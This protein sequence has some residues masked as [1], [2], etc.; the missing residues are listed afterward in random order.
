MDTKA[1]AIVQNKQ[2]KKVICGDCILSLIKLHEV[3]PL[4]NFQL[5]KRNIMN[6]HDA[7]ELARTLMNEHGLI[8]WIFQYD[9]AK[10]RED[11]A[12]TADKPSPLAITMSLTTK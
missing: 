10:Q 12:N 3:Y 8:T 9:R 11:A 2:N 7:A 4:F 1:L 6:T 5:T